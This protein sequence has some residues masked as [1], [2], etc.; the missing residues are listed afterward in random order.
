MLNEEAR[1]A[2]TVIELPQKRISELEREKKKTRSNQQEETPSLQN[3]SKCL[4]LGDTNL[5]R[6]LNSD[7]GDN[8]S[9]KTIQRANMD[10]LTSW[11][12]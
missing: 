10:L 8:W 5:K 2:Y 7:L 3:N 6:I 1:T 11:V 12:R 4:F 9:V